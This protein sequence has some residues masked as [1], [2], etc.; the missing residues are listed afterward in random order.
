MSTRMN[1]CVTCTLLA[2]ELL[3]GFYSYSGFKSF[4]QRRL[5]PTEYEYSGSKTRLPSVEPSK[6]K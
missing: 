2:P 3:D 6:T 4:P 1:V 5:V